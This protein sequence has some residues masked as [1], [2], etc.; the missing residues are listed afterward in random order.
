MMFVSLLLHL[1]KENKNVSFLRHLK[2][3]S[4]LFSG[5]AYTDNKI[6][7]EE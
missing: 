1:I 3:L 6:T 7:D 2:N 5:N 4:K